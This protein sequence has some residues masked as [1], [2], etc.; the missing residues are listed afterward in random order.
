M[1]KVLSLVE[2]GR[3]DCMPKIEVEKLAGRKT[4][5]IIVRMRMFWP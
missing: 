4:R 5:D 2:A 1:T 3:I